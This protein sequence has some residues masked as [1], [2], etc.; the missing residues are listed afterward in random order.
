MAGK[1]QTVWTALA[2]ARWPQFTVE[3][4]GRFAVLDLSTG[5]VML[6]VWRMEAVARFNEAR[7][8]RRIYVMEHAPTEQPIMKKPWEN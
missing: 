1:K 3:G 7:F 5:A 2:A 4:D 6:F 8:R